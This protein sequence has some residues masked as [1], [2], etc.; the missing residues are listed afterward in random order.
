M[1]DQRAQNPASRAII[2]AAALL[3]I[4][5]APARPADA[6]T[7][8]TPIHPSQQTA[9]EFGDRSH[10]L[11][12]WRGYLD[13]VPAETFRDAVG[14]NFNVEP[15]QADSTARLL[16]ES[17]FRRAR[18]E[19]GWSA[20][21]FSDRSRLRTDESV[22]TTLTALRDHGIRPLILLNSHHGAPCPYRFF[23]VRLVQDAPQGARTIR[24][25][26]ATAAAIEPGRTG[27]NASDDYKAAAILFT[28]VQPDGTVSLSKPLPRA[29]K[30]GAHPAATLAYRPFERPR[31]A[32]G[33]PNPDFEETLAG[34]LAYVDVVTRRAREILGSTEFDVEVWNE[35]SFGSDFLD[36]SRYYDP[37]PDVGV[38]DTDREILERTVAL[39]R[40]PARGM[41][42]VGIGNG[43]ANQRPWEAGGTSPP[44]LTAIDKHPYHGMARFPEDAVNSGIRPLDANGQPNGTRLGPDE[45]REGFVPTYGAF[46][47]EH[48]L[49]AIQT[50][51]LVRDL[52]PITTGVYGT[53]H[54]RNTHPAGSP[55]PEVWITET[56]MDFTEMEQ[57][58]QLGSADIAHLRA[59]ATL[60]TTTAFVNKGVRGLHFYAARGDELGLIDDSFFDE[61]DR[62]G[63][64][65]PGPGTAGATVAAMARMMSRF[66]PGQLGAPRQLSLEQIADDHDQRQFEGG[67]T[68]GRPPLYN[69][70]VLAF[71]PFQV[72]DNRFV[73]GVYVMTR[74]ITRVNRPELPPNDPAR[75]DLPPAPYRLTIG[76]L[77]GEGVQASAYDPLSDEQVPVEVVS[78]EP[79]RA[80]IEL[81]VTDSPRLLVLEDSGDPPSGEAPPSAPASPSAPAPPESTPPP[82]PPSVGPAARAGVQIN[83]VRLRNGRILISG[84]ATGTRGVSLAV[85]FQAGRRAFLVRRKIP[86]ES[87]PFEARLTLPSSARQARRIRRVGVV[88]AA[89]GESHQS[90]WRV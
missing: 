79:D 39:I 70:D 82:A 35:L 49:T 61:V 13:T 77:D 62:R 87:G 29:L 1:G 78:R 81:P 38:G 21:D 76:N 25:D 72:A 34:W 80:V 48:Y 37:A 4:L 11:Q 54:G 12:P 32:D 66:E 88:A 28:G 65:Y 84:Q 24:V 2:A 33:S 53:P 23:D 40:D 56:G 42:G 22:R 18:I 51:H 57:A 73:A 9:L 90:R 5:L 16:R 45:W 15:G 67:G 7:L 46:F 44:G 14:I 31:L 69:R 27:L 19:V 50:E 63:G 58:G 20:I 8:N 83:S 74:D 30:A 47:P 17:G 26:S 36:A 68:S 55:P 10:W 60:R 64:A 43:F 75:F 85:R 59:K 3:A 52:S 89:S 71:L 86:T 6:G 41:Q